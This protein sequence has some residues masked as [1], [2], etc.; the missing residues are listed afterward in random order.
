V[1]AGL[2]A[3]LLLILGVAAAGLL[4][5]VAVRQGSTFWAAL[6]AS[7][8]TVGAAVLVRNF[9]RRRVADSIRRERLSDIYTEMAQVL[10]GRDMPQEQRDELMLNFMRHTLVYASPRTLKTFRTWSVNLPEDPWTK[11]DY[12]ASTLRY[13]AFV[14][15][16]RDDLGI[17][18]RG[19][20]DGDLARVGIYDFDNPD[21]P[22]AV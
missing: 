21:F 9:E 22:E 7:G 1:I 13:E 20:A 11:D 5:V 12:T 14:K 4:F 3:L 15:A 17:S 6:L 2:F 10:H 8:A 19:L 18:N 16:M